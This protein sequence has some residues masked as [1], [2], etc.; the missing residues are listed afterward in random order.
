VVCVLSAA[1]QCRQRRR[2]RP[3]SSDAVFRASHRLAPVALPPPPPPGVKNAHS[4]CIFGRNWG[5]AQGKEFKHLHF[6][7]CYYQARACGYPRN[8]SRALEHQG[9]RLAST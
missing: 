1:Q 3:L 5:C 9:P 6:E 8:L 7:L 4:H 2:L